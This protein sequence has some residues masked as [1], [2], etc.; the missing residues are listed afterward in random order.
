MADHHQPSNPPAGHHD[1][2]RLAQL[3]ELALERGVSLCAS[4]LPCPAAQALGDDDLAYVTDLLAHYVL[5]RHS[6]LP[7][8]VCNALLHAAERGA[9][10]TDTL[11]VALALYEQVLARTPTDR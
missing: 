4:D 5:S 8:S 6:A 11:L 2:D 7:M 3:R 1:S 9:N 10:A